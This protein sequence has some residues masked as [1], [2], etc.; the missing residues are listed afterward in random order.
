MAKRDMKAALKNSIAVEEQSV[1]NRFEKAETL[2][3]ESRREKLPAD[4]KKLLQEE[5]EKKEKVVRDSFTMPQSDYE[6]IAA[7]KSRSLNS[8]IQTNKSE[9]LRAGLLAL[10]QMSETDFLDKIG[11]VE[12][13]KT[14][15]P[16]HTV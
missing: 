8:G 3:G 6:L 1:Q 16:K 14:G 11:D 2:L 5:N 10:F 15:R 9:I 12:K 13:I 4:A 7:L